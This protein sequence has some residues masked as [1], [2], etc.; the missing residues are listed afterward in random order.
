VFPVKRAPNR[1]PPH[2]CRVAT[3]VEDEIVEGGTWLHGATFSLDRH[4]A[5][6]DRP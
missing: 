2:R 6:R 3:L 1:G 5:E 4:G